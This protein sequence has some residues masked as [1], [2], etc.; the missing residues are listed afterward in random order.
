MDLEALRQR[1]SNEVGPDVGIA[2]K[3]VEGDPQLLWPVER[4]AVQRAIPRRQR[5]FASGRVAA[6]EALAQIAWPAEAIPCASD[7]SPVWPQGLVGSIAHNAQVCVAMVGRCERVPAIGVDIEEDKDIEPHLW[8]M[9][10]TPEELAVLSSVPRS[11]QGRSVTRLFCA[12][13]AF[14]KWQFPQT[15]RLL[16]FHDVQV[17]LNPDQTGFRVHTPPVDNTPFPS[18]GIQGRLLT[19]ESLVLA[20]VIGRPTL[21]T[22]FK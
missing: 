11:L 4:E 22:R 12:K 1:L 20:W 3:S 19:H 17:L 6:R 10:C 8:K 2:C 13:E 5:E 15:R 7:R 21:G 16:D 14:Y 9:I 18:I